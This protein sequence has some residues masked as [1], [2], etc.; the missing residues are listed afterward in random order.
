[1]SNEN[2]SIQL[3]RIERSAEIVG[4]LENAVT[5]AVLPI[6]DKNTTFVPILP[7]RRFQPHAVSH[8][9]EGRQRRTTRWRR[10]LRSDASNQEKHT[11][12]REDARPVFHAATFDAAESSI[13][14]R[15][16]PGSL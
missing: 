8:V 3:Q 10:R 14:V 11:N 15:G 12:N 7:S 13:D 6:P 16:A 1:M 2:W 4:K 5:W 9:H